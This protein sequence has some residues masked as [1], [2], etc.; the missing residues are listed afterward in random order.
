MTE[1]TNT[2]PEPAG[3]GQDAPTFDADLEAQQPAPAEPVQ[4]DEAVAR[5]EA[6]PDGEGPDDQ[7][8]DG[9]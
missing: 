3:D 9:A 4:N 2:T 1:P 7:H 8:G 5:A 6:A